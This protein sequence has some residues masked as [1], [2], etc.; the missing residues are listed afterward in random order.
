[1]TSATAT[2]TATA[3][4]AATQSGSATPARRDSTADG[5][6]AK[7]ASR[8]GGGVAGDHELEAVLDALLAVLRR[9][10]TSNRE[11]ALAALGSKVLPRLGGAAA[12][13][14]EWLG[15]LITDEELL[16]A[17]IQD[18]SLR[19]AACHQR[20]LGLTYQL[21]ASA[22]E[23][24]SL[25]LEPWCPLL[26]AVLDA[27]DDGGGGVVSGVGGGDLS[28]AGSRLSGGTA[29]LDG[30]SSS[31]ADVAGTGGSGGGGVAPGTPRSAPRTP[32]LSGLSG[33]R[34]GMRGAAAG[35]DADAA[36]RSGLA[37]LRIVG[38]VC[39]SN[40]RGNAM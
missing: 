22:P 11:A 25:A 32:R 24:M 14:R 33:D 35:A 1:M 3:T 29:G 36:A 12:G 39:K 21:L 16:V 13:G 31:G 27:L 19:G 34:R 15:E 2:A 7:K 18:R 30:S 4:A 5:S 9:G 6:S 20:A 23:L 38:L 37:V 10:S 26:P 8:G 17:A 40:T 28:A